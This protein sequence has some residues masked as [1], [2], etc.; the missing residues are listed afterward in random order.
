MQDEYFSVMT[1]SQNLITA[2]GAGG[3]GMCCQ[4]KET[5]W[6]RSKSGD[7]VR[8]LVCLQKCVLKL[9]PGWDPTCSNFLE[10]L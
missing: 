10:R 4:W 7:A 5:V 9:G 6:F 3:A 1:R 8:T 2:G